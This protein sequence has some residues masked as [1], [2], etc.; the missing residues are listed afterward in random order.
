M[1]KNNKVTAYILYAVGEIILVMVGI[2]LALQVNNWNEQRSQRK[3]LDNIIRIVQNDLKTDTILASRVITYYE[4]NLKV[5]Q[6]VLN[7]NFTRDSIVNCLQC[8]SLITVY[9]PL[10][11]QNKGFTQIQNFANDNV[12]SDSLVADISALYTVLGELIKDSNTFVKDE[13]LEN[14]AHFKK[15]EWFVGW[16]SGQNNEDMFNY[17]ASQDFKNRVMGHSILAAQNHLRFA[18]AYKQNAVNILEEIEKRFGEIDEIVEKQK[19][20]ISK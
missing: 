7:P 19:D 20:T 12:K 15:Q 14:L 8:R 2:L 10:T 4:D 1:L 18:T 17:M 5:S 6:R 9:R 3:K 11:L 16:A 13:V